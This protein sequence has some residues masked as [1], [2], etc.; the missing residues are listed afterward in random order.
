MTEAVK[1]HVKLLLPLHLLTRARV[2]A[3]DWDVKLPSRSRKSLLGHKNPQKIELPV[4]LKQP[5]EYIAYFA[6]DTLLHPSFY[7]PFAGRD[8]HEPNAFMA[9]RFPIKE[10]TIPR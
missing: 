7:I 3:P 4:P 8:K 2:L 5:I 10:R 6:G 1:H 9:C